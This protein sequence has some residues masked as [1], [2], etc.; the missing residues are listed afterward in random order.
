MISSPWL[1]EMNIS[2]NISSCQ[3]C[4]PGQVVFAERPLLVALPGGILGW[5][6]VGFG[7]KL[8]AKLCKT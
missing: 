1:A 7:S 5:D 4:E 8:S 2:L 3:A 6:M